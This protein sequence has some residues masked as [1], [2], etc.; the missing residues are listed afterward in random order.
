VKEM[1][2]GKSFRTLVVVA[3]VLVVIMLYSAALGGS[4]NI[5]SATF[6]LISTPVQRL[7]AKLTGSSQELSDVFAD[8][9]AL[10]EENEAL[11]DKVR[12]LTS[13]LVDYEEMKQENETLK[14]ILGIKEENPDF[15]FVTA[16]VISRDTS[17]S[18][19]PF[20]IDAGTSDG[21]ALYDPI[22][23]ADGLVGY[24]S[25]VGPVSSKVTTVLSSTINIG[26][27]DRRTR[28][29]GVVSGTSSLA[30][31]GTTKFGLLQRDCDVSTG[32]IIVTSGLGG[33]FPPNVVIGEVTDVKPEPQSISLYAVI[34]PAADILECREV[35]VLVDFEGQGSVVDSELVNTESS[36]PEE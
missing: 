18:Y 22:M 13:S 25:E 9:V 32:D 14:Q 11:K 12:E 10:S 28:D 21:V 31:D 19:Q 35:F 8:P 17:D 2:Q 4:Q 24:V 27:F 29:N 1:L 3:V 15:E 16:N 6:S 23:T 26:A 20:T 5:F 34:T 30:V 33:I 36:N 7:S